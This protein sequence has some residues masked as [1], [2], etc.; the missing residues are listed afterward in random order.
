MLSG[1]H[2]LS[3]GALM[4]Q[5]CSLRETFTFEQHGGRDDEGPGALELLDQ[6]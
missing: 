1:V 6:I 4:S 2:L 3:G 5:E